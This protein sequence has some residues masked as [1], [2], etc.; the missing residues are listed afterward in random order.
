MD[1]EL[2]RIT[3]TCII[4]K[5]G[6]YFLLQ[7]SFDKKAFPGKWTVPGGG[8]STDDYVNTPSS[9]GAGQ[10]YYAIEKTLRR[11]VKEETGLEIGK[12]QYLLD[13]TFIIP[14]GTPCMVLSFYAPY[15]SGEVKLDEDSIDYKWVTAKEA[16]NYDLIEGIANEIKMVDD[17][18]NIS[19]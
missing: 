11:E 17:L 10:W 12:P 18:L 3:S 19:Q 5:D 14:D 4:N 1:K 8:F 6:K 16:E 9:T 7:R 2:H 15:V 13:L